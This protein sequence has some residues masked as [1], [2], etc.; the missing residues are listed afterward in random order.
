MKKTACILGEAPG[1]NGDPRLPLGG[2][3]YG[4]GKRLAKVIGMSQPVMRRAF[5][6]RNL[7]DEFPGFS[8]KG[9]VFPVKIARAA[10]GD[11]Q[12]E[13]D[14][15]LLLGKRLAAAFRL[16][17]NY[18]EWVERDGKQYV[19]VPHPSGV[20]R[21]YNSPENRRAAREFFRGLI[22]AEEG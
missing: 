18:F 4:S 20:N 7:L 9:A 15:I 6:L 19:V 11:F 22:D 16:N 2:C 13:E 12:C 5:T 10:V 8:G 14:R 1:F 3:R 17:V 21:W